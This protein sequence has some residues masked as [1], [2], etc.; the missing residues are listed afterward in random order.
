MKKLEI[1][2][3]RRASVT[4]IAKDLLGQYLCTN[5]EGA[6]TIGRIVETEAYC[7]ATDKAC[8]AFL[9]RRTTRTEVMFENGGIAYVYLCYGI[10]SLFN[11]VTNVTGKADAV[12]VRAIEPVEGAEI[13]MQ[14]R[15]MNRVKPPMLAG[16]GRLT[17]ALGITTKHNATSL[18]SN[19]IWISSGSKVADNQIIATPRIGID[20]AEEDALLPWRYLVR[21]S[22][23]ISGTKK[24]NRPIPADHP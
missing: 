16:P 8:H 12:L 3:Y 17:Q 13:M 1:D 10:H 20:Y 11:I 2:F 9:N 4:D 21:G 7:G 24:Q 6:Q 15:N 14:R 22:K 18:D 19:R 23:W 5:I